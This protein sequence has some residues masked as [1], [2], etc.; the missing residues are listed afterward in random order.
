M[1]NR[2]EGCQ[3]SYSPASR[4]SALADIF[5]CSGSAI[6]K[7]QT[8]EIL[9]FVSKACFFIIYFVFCDLLSY[10]FKYYLKSFD[11]AKAVFIKKAACAVA[12][13]LA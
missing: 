1:N 7:M 8:F 13:S 12:K 11:V 6:I 4:W 10:H 5:H 2:V 9:V 3:P